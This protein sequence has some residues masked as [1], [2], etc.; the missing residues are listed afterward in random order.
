MKSGLVNTLV[1]ATLY[2]ACMM[3]V[4]ANAGSDAL[5]ALQPN[6][7]KIV[8]NT[9]KP[10]MLKENI[11]GMAVA[12][13]QGGKSWVFNYG[14]IS[15]ESQK[16]V[17]NDTLFEL[18]SISKTFTATLATWAQA[19]NLLSLSDPVEK[20]L[21]ALKNTQ[22]GKVPLFHLATHTAGGLPLQVPNDLKTEAQLIAYFKQWEPKYAMG[23][24]RTYANPSIGTLGLIT[25]KMMGRDFSGVIEQRLFPALGIKNSFIAVPQQKIENYAQGYTNDDQPIRLASGLLAAEA[26]GVKATAGDMIRFVEANMGLYKLDEKLQKALMETHTGYFKVGT[27]TQDLIW[28]QYVYP[29]QLK[30]LLEGNSKEAIFNAMPVTP[31]NPPLKPQQNVWMNKTGS[32]NGFSAYVAFIPQKKLGIVILANK[33]FGIPERINIAH[34]ILTSLNSV[35]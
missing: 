6:M 23:T 8:D 15:K 17:T 3:P 14:V 7:Q 13:T 30:T 27:M 2:S 24:H 21:P 11:P 10:L 1:V 19:N 20:Y 29:V 35:K 33:S 22:F 34:Q 26:Y 12:I 16:P 5:D 9:I 31:I 25:A 4:V 32:T 28:E 18:G